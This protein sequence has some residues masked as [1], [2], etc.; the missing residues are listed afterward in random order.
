MTP[1]TLPIKMKK[2]PR[3]KLKKNCAKL[4]QEKL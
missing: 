4:T 3:G 1:F 2:Y